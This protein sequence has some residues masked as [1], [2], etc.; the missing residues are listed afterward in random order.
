MPSDARKFRFVSPGIFINEI[1]QSQIPTIP[2]AVGPVVVGRAQKGPGM[3]P[4]KVG[5]FS[6][7]VERFG[8]PLSGVG[9]DGDVWRLGNGYGAPSYGAYAAQAYLRAG[10][11]PVT[12]IRL[13]GTQSPDA[14]S[15]GKAGWTTTATAPT[16]TVSTNGGAYGLFLF[17]SGTTGP[18][19]TNKGTLAAVWYLNSGAIIL[20]GAM[21]SPAAT[22][23]TT[24]A[25][26]VA[27]KAS[28]VGDYKAQIFNASNAVV[29]DVTFNLTEGSRHF[30]RNVFNTNP[31][32]AGAMADSST[33][34]TYWLGETYESFVSRAGT[35]EASLAAAPA[36]Y[37][38]I[39]AVAN[40]ANLDGPHEQRIPYRDA[41]SGWFFAQSLNADTSSYTH[42]NAK[43]LF[44]FVGING[45]GSW[46]HRNLKIS[47]SNI[48]APS[49]DNVKYGAFDV[50]IRKASDSDLGAV[51]VERFSNCNLDP[52]S[53]NYIARKIGDVSVEFDNDEK[54]YREFGDYP[55]NSE[56][57]RVVVH[58]NV[59]KID[60]KYLPFGI[61]GPPKY[62]GWTSTAASLVDTN[63]NPSGS[64]FA[65]GSN[66][67]PKSGAS[68]TTFL[69]GAADAAGGD[70]SGYGIATIEYPE[71]LT[72]L[73]CS[74]TTG[75]GANPTTNAYF[76]LQ[77]TK[78]RTST[79]FDNGYVD[80][81]RPL[82]ADVVSD[83][84]WVD[85]FGINGYTSPLVPQ[86]KFTLDEV[87][88]T[89]DTTSYSATTPTLGI[90]D[91]FYKS[92]S[93]ADG[94]S[95][96]ATSSTGGTA[97]FEN[98]L[99]AKVNRFTSPLFGGFDGVDITERDP[100]RNTLI[101]GTSPTEETS[102]VF[103]S[104][105]RAINTVADAEV[106]EMNAAAI[107]GIWHEET[108]KYLID[109]CEA[110]GDTLAII[111]LKGGFVPRHES[112]SSKSVRK[113]QL[114]DVLTNIKARNLNSSYAAAYY[115]WVKVRDDQSGTIVNMPPSVVALGV[116]AN[117]ERAADVWFAPAGFSRGGLSLGAG[118]LTVSGVETKLTSRNRD[119][120]YEVN[121]NPIASFPSEGIVVFGQ[122]TLQATPSALDRINVRRLLIFLKRGIS[123][124]ASTTLFQPNVQ[125]TW[126]SFKSRADEFL[127]DVQV[128]FGLDEFRVLLDETTTTPDLVDRNI[129]YA[130]IFVKPTRAIEFIAI[131]FIITRSGA[132]FDD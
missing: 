89:Y 39:L 62:P 121:I 124:I 68:A 85:D 95:F 20:S 71:V 129:L 16:D 117:T 45:H 128:R 10:V 13:M 101:D 132:S 82:G 22:A 93:F 51:I 36:S 1:D 34:K 25:A 86:F 87:V 27:I 15:A 66:K 100:F 80:Y 107:P 35:N 8:N 118:G 61:F 47:I 91:A 46:L 14:T 73:S 6:E 76:G 113:G 98:I 54:R 44:K 50:E 21:A 26:G 78:T 109:T 18:A 58:D 28:S 72:R 105:R 114:G 52:R 97:N 41:H 43:K 92:G 69:T 125:A 5:S 12:F 108:T 112:T 17:E 99:N 55:N 53:S 49:N 57:V 83:A 19:A 120:L 122:K 77:T 102:Y 74:N 131:D 115:P 4:T 96:N 33:S 79:V 88:V 48:K 103:F 60:P 130:K 59:G 31:E 2:D 64:A 3:I 106:V 24:G 70:V 84:N 63:G 42:E 40:G 32:S 81:L 7:F 75:D 29:E 65:L 90:Q 94:T 67:I 30:I 37:A 119:D 9:T 56:Y 123:R 104:L 38:A 126:N 23:P 111:D 127:G 11:G 110:R 116:L